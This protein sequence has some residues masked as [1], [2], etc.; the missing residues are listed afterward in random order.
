MGCTGWYI[1]NRYQVG[2]SAVVA[3]HT[4]EVDVLPIV[5]ARSVDNAV[6]LKPDSPTAFDPPGLALD[7]HQTTAFFEG[8]IE[9]GLAKRNEHTLAGSGERGQDGG[10]G[11]LAYLRWRHPFR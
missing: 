6:G 9:S 1:T 10:L 8:E 3:V 5:T 7:L 2:L 4:K 11:A